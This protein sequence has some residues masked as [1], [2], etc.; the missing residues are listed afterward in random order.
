MIEALLLDL[1]GT[2]LDN[3]IDA[4]LPSYLKAL[5]RHMAPWVPPD[6]LVPQLLKSTSVMLANRQPTRTL[7]Q[8]FAED[9][10]PALG[11]TEAALLPH[12]E[13]FYRDEFPKL[14]GL[15]HRREAAIRI[16]QT[17]LDAGV[18]VVVATNPLFPRMAID[19]RLEWAGVP[20]RVTPYSVVTSYE[21]FHSAKPQPAYYAEILGHLGLHAARAAMVGDN[22][23]DDLL[24][25]QSLGMAAFH[26][27][28]EPDSAFPGGSLEDA[29]AWLTVADRE[30][31]PAAARQPSSV[32]ARLHGQLGTLLTLL[33]ELAPEMWTRRPAPGAWS[34]TEI[35]CHL[36]DIDY[37][38]HQ[39]RLE[40]ILSTASPFLPAVDTD[41]WADVR[42]YAAQSGPDALEL[43]AERRVQ[44][45][46]QLE[47]LPSEAWDRPARHALLGPTS[48][49]EVASIAADHELLHLADIRLQAHTG[50]LPPSPIDR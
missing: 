43:L 36:R 42:H 13:A 48:L 20:A 23:Q 30:T 22:V 1:D 46:R 9:F 44:L 5:S 19:H 39:P 35:V 15:T 50:E 14:V 41:P 27:A 16:V 12:F 32:L 17:A 4:F 37:E 26:V 29:T 40:R 18:R 31:N 47:S 24:P 45:L 49:A 10:Y 34:L 25:A 11:T 33:G 28:Q 8:T 38:V 2:L 6:R 7:Q 3:D 21:T